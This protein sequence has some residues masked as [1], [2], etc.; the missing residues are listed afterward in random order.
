MKKQEV[1]KILAPGTALRYEF[2]TIA[3][4]RL[5]ASCCFQIDTRMRFL[6]V[7]SHNQLT[8]SGVT[9]ENGV[10]PFLYLDAS[11]W[12]SV[13]ALAGVLVL[14]NHSRF[15]VSSALRTMRAALFFVLTQIVINMQATDGRKISC[16]SVRLHA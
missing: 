15:S 3:K 9:R 13:D 14:F 12:F 1:I 5:N 10:A 7:S 11:S 6:V 4:V 8:A 16:A 2:I